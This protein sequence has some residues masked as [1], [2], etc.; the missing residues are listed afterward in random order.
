[1]PTFDPRSFILTSAVAGIL[2][3]LIFFV[4]RRSFPRDIGGVGEWGWACLSTVCGAFLL[5]MRDVLPPFFSIVLANTMIVAGVFLMHV[6]VRRFAD[7]NAGYGRGAG[8]MLLLLACLV[9]LTVAY[10]NYRGRVVLVTLVNMGLFGA[11]AVVI[12]RMRKRGFGEHFTA[13]VFAAEALMSLT[14][15][16]F[17]FGG[18]GS[19]DYRNDTT[20]IQLV[21]MATFSVALIALSLGFM[22]MVTTRMQE[23]LQYAASHDDLSGAYTRAT[24][25]D[26]M[27]KEIERSRRHSGSL[28]LL[29][30]DIDDFKLINDQYGH[31]VGDR[32]I[33]SFAAATASELRSHDVFCRY[34]GEEFA[35][36]LPDTRLDEAVAVAE[37]IRARL[38]HAA[39]EGLPA[40]TVSIGVQSTHARALDMAQLIEGADQALYIAKKLGKDRVEI[41][42]DAAGGGKAGEPAQG[43]FTAR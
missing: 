13:T 26:L 9:W 42:P 21:Y 24:F 2:C 36:L 6:S 10:D 43:S 1:M 35:L 4:L 34:G 27:G 3:T 39:P 11:S 8:I 30:I 28:S 19:S 15:F 22:L 14:R 32:V 25:F 18:L 20:L 33:R 7:L 40:F 31:P 38:G 37:R 41:A 23:R 17:A 12:F 5:S 29:I 16:V